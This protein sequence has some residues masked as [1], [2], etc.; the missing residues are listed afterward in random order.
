MSLLLFRVLDLGVPLLFIVLGPGVPYYLE[1]WDQ[2]SP[3]YLKFW[4]QVFPYYL[5]VRKPTV[6]VIDYRAAMSIHKINV[7]TFLA[8]FI[9]I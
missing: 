6:I 5:E 2:V 8:S 9:F 3:Y 1:Y 7:K 4:V